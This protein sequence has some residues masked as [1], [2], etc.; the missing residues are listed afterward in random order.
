MQKE[1]A[2]H[3]EILETIRSERREKIKAI[4]DEAREG[5]D[6]DWE[7]VY[8]KIEAVAVN[9]AEAI[10]SEHIRHHHDVSR[11]LSE[12]KSKLIERFR[13]DFRRN[14]ERRRERRN[15]AGA[16]GGP[17][18]RGGPATGEELEGSVF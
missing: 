11:I 12:N 5:E 3:R 10:L 8:Q 6:V 7:A 14:W 4:L 1:I 18:K 16:E 13:R 17:R 2:R 9:S 15:E